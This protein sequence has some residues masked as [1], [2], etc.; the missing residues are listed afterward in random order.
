MKD[1]FLK[2]IIQNVLMEQSA[3]DHLLNDLKKRLRSMNGSDQGDF[4]EWHEDVAKDQ[5]YYDDYEDGNYVKCDI[6][7]S[8]LKSV[9]VSG[10]HGRPTQSSVFSLEAQEDVDKIISFVEKV[11]GLIE[12]PSYI[13]N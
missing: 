6:N 7:F 10:S 12:N 1:K 2:E 11:S 4:G 5:W 8:N 3:N 9:S 13:E